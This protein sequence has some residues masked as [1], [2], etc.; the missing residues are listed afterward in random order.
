MGLSSAAWSA[1]GI[2]NCPGAGSGHTAIA[3]VD[4]SAVAILQKRDR[5]KIIPLAMTT[6]TL[7]LLILG[8]LYLLAGGVF[9]LALVSAAARPC[10]KF[11]GVYA[12]STGLSDAEV[13]EA[14]TEEF[15]RP[16]A[17]S[18]QPFRIESQGH[19]IPVAR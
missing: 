8:G 16:K 12:V 13:V 10:P 14:G 9:C 7:T 4:E 5:P 3:F 1:K 15:T 19:P 17:K 18:R 2:G 6:L 11:D